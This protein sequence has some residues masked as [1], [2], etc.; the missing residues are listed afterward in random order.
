L[1]IWNGAISAAKKR[2]DLEAI[3]SWMPHP[4][5][6][7]DDVAATLSPGMVHPGQW[8]LTRRDTQLTWLIGFSQAWKDI[9]DERRKEL[10]DDPWALKALAETISAPA[11]E[12]ARL[13]LLHLTHPDTFEP[14]VSPNHKRYIVGR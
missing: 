2:S 12:S 5:L 6:I 11:S 14:I 7:P 10:L 13:A 8:V 3:L 4:C 9:T 1:I